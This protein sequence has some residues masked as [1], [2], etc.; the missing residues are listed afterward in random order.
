MH[1]QGYYAKRYGIA[2]EDFP[3]ALACHERTLAL[4]LHNRM[5]DDDYA[6]VVECLRELG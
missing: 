6:F 1:L 4:P 5:T 2:P 3:G